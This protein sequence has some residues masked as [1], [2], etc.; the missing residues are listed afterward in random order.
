MAGKLDP[1]QKI[2]RAAKRGTGLRLTA[3][4]VFALSC[5]DAIEQAASQDRANFMEED[6]KR[7]EEW[8]KQKAVPHA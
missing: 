5:D 1:Y 8:R 6:R 2:M 3:G 7:R 4:E